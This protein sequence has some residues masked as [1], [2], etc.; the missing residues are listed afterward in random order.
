[1]KI[2]KEIIM[3]EGWIIE[4]DK[5]QF[6][7]IW[8]KWMCGFLD[9]IRMSCTKEHLLGVLHSYAIIDVFIDTWANNIY[10]YI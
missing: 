5:E 6:L 2:I 7:T 1:M 3:N 4:L 9:K 8:Q 10:I